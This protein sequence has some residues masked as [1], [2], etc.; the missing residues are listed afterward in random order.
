[1]NIYEIG[2]QVRCSAAFTV[3]GVATDPTT[4]TFKYRKPG[5]SVVTLT[6]G[7]DGSV[8]KSSTGGYYVD[9][10]PDTSGVWHIG[11][12]GTGSVVAAGESSFK[13]SKSNLT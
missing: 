8:V 9:L 2:D 12:Y 1:M 13:V 11:F 10:T 3:N 6:Y 4:I 5:G 7:V